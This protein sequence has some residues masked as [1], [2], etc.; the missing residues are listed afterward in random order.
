MVTQA[1]PIGFE[2]GSNNT[3]TEGAGVWAAL[4]QTILVTG[5]PSPPLVLGVVLEPPDRFPMNT[6]F[7]LQGPQWVATDHLCR[8][9]PGADLRQGCMCR[10]LIW[11]ACREDR[12]Q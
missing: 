9:F 5:S 2:S 11:G 6:P 7:L 1:E 4:C 3:K 12:Q 8:R 10:Q